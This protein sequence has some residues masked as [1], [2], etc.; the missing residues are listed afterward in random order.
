MA[1]LPAFTAAP[2]GWGAPTPTASHREPVAIT[3]AMGTLNILRAC[4]FMIGRLPLISAF[5]KINRRASPKQLA[6]SYSRQGIT[7]RS[8]ARIER[9][10]K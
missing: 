7:T 6:Y 1:M 3:A 9:S 8:R 2:L 4:K 10:M 5:P